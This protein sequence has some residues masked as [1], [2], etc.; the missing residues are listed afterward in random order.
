MD[1]SRPRRPSVDPSLARLRAYQEA[2]AFS[3][4]VFDATVSFPDLTRGSLADQVRRAA[5]SVFAN[6]A[7]GHGRTTPAD[8]RRLWT[9]ASGSLSEARAYLDRAAERDLLAPDLHDALRTRAV[10]T[11]RLLAALSR[12][13]QK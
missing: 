7:E 2:C 10:H 11:A 9:I 3:D 13:T 4:A 1:D 12:S 5:D 8:K 6:I